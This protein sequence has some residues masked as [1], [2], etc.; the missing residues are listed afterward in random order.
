[1]SDTAGARIG[2]IGLG[3]MGAALA[4][5]IADHGFPVAVYNRTTSVTGEFLEAAGALRPRLI[6]SETLDSFVASLDSPRAVIIMVNAGA[7]VD[8]VIADLLPHLD[9]GDLI[10]DAGNADFNDTRRREAALAAQGFDFIGMGVSGG[11]EGARHGPAVMA[12]GPAASYERI[13]DI[14]EAIAA[15][16]Q[17]NPCAAHCGP[18]G[19]GHFVKTVHNGIEY[20]DMQMIAEIWGLLRDGAGMTP[21]QAG[22]IFSRWDQGPLKSYLVEISGKVLA[23]TDP[24]TGRPMV[25]LIEDRAGQKGTGRWTLIE[26]LRM[27][28]SATT[29]EA[30]VAARSFSSMKPV[31]KVGEAIFGLPA[32]ADVPKEAELEAGLLAAKIVAYSQGLTLL[33]AASDEFKWNLNLSRIAEI[34]RAGCIIRSALLDDISRAVAAGLPEGQLIFAPAFA[35]RLKTGIPALR[36]VVAAAALGGHAAPALS[37]ALSFFDQMVRAR[38]TADLIQGQRDFFGA[39]G[40]ERT[41]RPGKDFHGP[42]AMAKG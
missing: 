30:A 24:D 1:M 35:E 16:Y 23:A 28:Q 7:P 18:D 33:A 5:N 25:D 38:G 29:I 26:A 41:D 36:R 4:M 12:G 17:G 15:K 21:A 34:W 22:A 42:W 2:L 39:H 13:R 37:A 31:R 32:P 9:K 20:G 27:G 8:A 6:G 19:A 40:F 14:I 10:I 11:E 3:T